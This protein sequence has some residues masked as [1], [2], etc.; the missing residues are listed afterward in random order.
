MHANGEGPLVEVG[1]HAGRMIQ[2]TLGITAIEEQ[3]AIQITVWGGPDPEHSMPKPL[4]VFPEKF[5]TG[6]SALFLDLARYPE[7]RFLRVKWRVHRW[8]RG[9]LTPMF[10]FYVF[11][12]PVS[13]PKPVAAP[14]ARGSKG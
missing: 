7:V 5:Y 6:L 14:A 12:E 13:L 8:G 10:R 2:L 4:L 9:S 1:E 3:Q 11:A